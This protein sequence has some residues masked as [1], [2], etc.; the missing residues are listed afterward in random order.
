MMMVMMVMVMM[1]VRALDREMEELGDKIENRHKGKNTRCAIH[2]HNH[3]KTKTRH[4]G[5]N[6]PSS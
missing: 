6:T 2:H 4:K 3:Q 5:K 1:R